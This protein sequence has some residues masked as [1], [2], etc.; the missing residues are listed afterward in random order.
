M[1][2]EFILYDVTDNIARITVNRPEVLNSITRQ[3][4]RELDE[5]FTEAENDDNVIVIVVA[6]AGDHFGSGH[7]MGSE[8]S[9]LEEE[10]NPRDR[11]PLGILKVMENGIYSYPREHWRNIPKPTI[12]MVQGYCIMASWML[13][14]AC[15]II[16][17]AEN[18][19]FQD[20][21]VR[22]WG[23]AQ[24]EYP[25]MYVELGAR[26]TKEYLW[27]GGFI[28]AQEACRLGIINRVVP[29]E[30]LEKETMEMAKTFSKIDPWGLMASKM[31]IN[32]AEEIMGKEAAIKASSRFWCLSQSKR[33][34]NEF[35][36]QYSVDW[37]KSRDKEFE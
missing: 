8:Q 12:A 31:A 13:A 6:G 18:A 37:V 36:S 10:R 33:D 25:A 35:K 30:Q 23:G 3:V 16:V 19:K 17:A 15:D 26:K 14:C 24:L 9:R 2:W 29:I 1:S 20:K 34:R 32:Q 4:Y 7:D 21:T 27:T 28:D 11:S 22:T 5:A